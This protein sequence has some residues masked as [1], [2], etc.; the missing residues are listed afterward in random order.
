MASVYIAG[1]G[2]RVGR[3]VAAQAGAV[4]L[5]V[6][7]SPDAAAAW[8]IALPRT[9]VEA[10]LAHWTAARDVA[11]VD[12]SG[13]FKARGVGSYALLADDRRVWS[14]NRSAPAGCSPTP[15]ASP[16]R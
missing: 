10:D 11:V 7:A 13:A 6:V 8:F 3:A 12:L 2:G 15:G 5:E 1:A 4:G 16:A 14:G 9:V